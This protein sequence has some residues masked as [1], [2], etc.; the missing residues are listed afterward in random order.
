V[1]IDHAE[2]RPRPVRDP[3]ADIAPAEFGEQ[4]PYGGDGCD[5]EVVSADRSAGLRDAVV[6]V[7]R[8]GGI[9]RH[10]RVA[11][12]VAVVAVLGVELVLGWPSLVAAFSQFR[13][14]HP[15]WLLGAVLVE[16]ASMRAYARMQRRLLRSAGIDAS[17]VQHVSL[18]YAAHSLSV[19]L[20]GGPAFSTSYNYQQMRRLGAT[21]GIAMWCIALS[22]GMSAAALAVLGVAGGIAAG[23]RPDW[24][25]LAAELGLVLA[26]GFAIRH[27]ARRPAAVERL[28]GAADATIARLRPGS[29]GPV[30]GF[31]TQLRAVRPR[32]VHLAG[33]GAYAFAN[34]LLDALCLWMS[35][36]AVGATTVTATQLLIAYCAGMAA[37]GALPIVPGGLG[38]VDSALVL[39]LVA[40]RLPTSTAIAAVLLYRLISLGFVVST[41]WAVWLIIRY[42]A[43]REHG[44]SFG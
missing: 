4:R 42:R 2:F 18:A 21:P 16:M 26:A 38:V 32:P 29:A 13:A 28:A 19:T 10:W 37:G 7:S 23:G 9:R 25:V 34:W 27:L 24:P 14:P 15:G 17:L 30:T 20:P 5:D 36:M 43:R 41:G 8:R 31:L 3:G 40:G 22:G 6:P 11:A 1:T 33:A 12:V 35:C 39:G 44:N